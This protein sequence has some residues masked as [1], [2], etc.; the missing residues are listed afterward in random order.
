MILSSRIR[1]LYFQAL[2]FSGSYNLYHLHGFTFRTTRNFSSFAYSLYSPA[3]CVN[4]DRLRIGVFY[5]LCDVLFL[6]EK[7]THHWTIH[8]CIVIEWLKLFQTTLKSERWRYGEKFSGDFCTWLP[9][10]YHGVMWSSPSSLYRCQFTQSIL[11][12]ELR[13]IVPQLLFM[14]Y[15]FLRPFNMKFDLSTG[16][17]QHMY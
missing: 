12:A 6:P 7:E 1:I 17:L 10:I 16:R 4:R 2:C 9:M 14:I 5:S 11:A 15:I 8:C 3:T 13:H